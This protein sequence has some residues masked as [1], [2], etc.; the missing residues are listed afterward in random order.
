MKRN[1][2]IKPIWNFIYIV[3]SIKRNK[4]CQYVF[5]QQHFLYIII[6]TRLAG[7]K[8]VVVGVDLGVAVVSGAT[9]FA[10]KRACENVPLVKVEALVVCRVLN[11]PA[12]VAFLAR[13]TSAAD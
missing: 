6:G 12:V 8:E 4:K 13:A 9:V 7:V 3:C 1:D 2:S 10:V 11:E 5:A